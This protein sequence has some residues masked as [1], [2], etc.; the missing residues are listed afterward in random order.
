MPENIELFQEEE[1]LLRNIGER[2]GCPTRVALTRALDVA[3]S[4]SQL[5]GDGRTWLAVYG[6]GRTPILVDGALLVP[7]GDE[8]AGRLSPMDQ[9]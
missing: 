8:E 7:S 2:V 9:A 3:D 4:L 5:L 6:P 1:E